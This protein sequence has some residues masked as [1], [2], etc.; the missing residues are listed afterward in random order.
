ML[1]EKKLNF[2]AEYPISCSL[3]IGDSQIK[4]IKKMEGLIPLIQES[5]ENKEIILTQFKEVKDKLNRFV[6]EVYKTHIDSVFLYAGKY[7]QQHPDMYDLS[8]PS[9]VRSINSYAKKLNKVSTEAKK[10]EMYKKA[11]EITDELMS[12]YNIITF[13]KDHTIKASDKKKQIEDV[14]QKQEDVWQ[15]KLTNHNDTK[16]V[17]E[18][19]KETA[20]NI[21]KKLYSNNIIEIN[22]IIDKYKESIELGQSDYKTVFKNNIFAII[23]LQSVTERININKDNN[24]N[25]RQ[26]RLIDTYE[27][28]VEKEANKMAEEIVGKFVYKN[29]SKISFILFTKDNLDIAGIKNIK[30][31]RG[32]IE[33]DV[34]CKFKDG[35]EFTANTSVV[36]AYSKYNKPFYR[37]PTLFRYVKL[38]DGTMLSNPSEKRMDEIFAIKKEDKLVERK[39][40]I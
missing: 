38:A 28:V 35:S 33:C 22:N 2:D 32:Y 20:I 15:K 8:S 40:K 39:N 31:G 17:I 25:N 36:L 1:L 6:D 16:K 10:T 4:I 18:L 11:V 34:E 26:F 14:K 13:L 27:E 23:I 29:A 9:E 5:L 7:Q 24:N 21:Q 19:L 30:L 37:Y 3:L 12:L